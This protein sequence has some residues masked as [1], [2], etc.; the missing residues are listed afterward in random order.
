MSTI[1]VTTKAA[2]LKKRIEQTYLLARHICQP[3]F[4]RF[5]KASGPNRRRHCWMRKSAASG[6]SLD[7][8]RGTPEQKVFRVRHW[9]ERPP[10]TL[11]LNRRLAAWAFQKLNTMQ[12]FNTHGR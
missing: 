3:D 10:K 7:Q 5:H 12:T 2:N 11:P 4:N 9:C 1:P 8:T 6:H